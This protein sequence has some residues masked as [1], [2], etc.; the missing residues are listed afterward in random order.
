MRATLLVL[1]AVIALAACARPSPA[2]TASNAVSTLVPTAEA[3][4]ASAAVAKATESAV[5]IAP[6]G[7]HGAT[8]FPGVLDTRPPG[9]SRIGEI[10]AIPKFPGTSGQVYGPPGEAVPPNEGP[11]RIV[12]Y[13]TMPGNDAYLK[14]RIEQSGNKDS[15]PI[16]VSV[17]GEH[18]MVW[19]DEA[20]GELVVGWSDRDKVD[21]LVANTAD[22]TINQLVDA[23]EGVSDC[24]G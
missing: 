19:L 14:S 6:C 13:E 2:P 5:Q 7:R 22:L 24:C 11:R 20:T 18:T 12:L 21:V 10:R 4:P 17:C 9:W 15:K 8:A 3:H 16:A 23:A 1:V